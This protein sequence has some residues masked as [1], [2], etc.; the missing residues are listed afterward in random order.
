DHWNQGMV[1]TPTT[2][3]D[4]HH[5]RTAL[6]ALS[7]Q[8]DALRAR[9]THTPEGW[10]QHYL[11][12]GTSPDLHET[13]GDITDAAAALQSSFNLQHGPLWGAAL[14]QMHDGTQRLAIAAH[15]LIVDGVSWRILLE[16]LSR[17]YTQLSN[18]TPV[19]P[20][21]RATSVGRW[22]DLLA[23]SADLRAE[24]SYWSQVLDHPAA[25]LPLDR[26]GGVNTTATL[27]RVDTHIDPT[28]TRQILDEVPA[29]YPVTGDELMTA[30]LYLC[31]RDWSG[32]NGLAVELESH[33]RADLDD[34]ADLSRTVGWLTGL[35]PVH[36]APGADA[37]VDTVLRT[38]KETLR[39]VPNTGI[40]YGV[41]RYI[42]RVLPDTAPADVRF[43]YLGRAGAMF[44]PGGLFTPAPEAPGPAQAPGTPR[45][46]ALEINA[47]ATDQGLRIG[48]NFSSGQCDRTTIE[49][50]SAGFTDH[51]Q[52]LVAHCLAGDDTGFSP[53]DFP[54]MDFD[55]DDLDSLLESL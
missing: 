35:Y 28:L 49:T 30:A 15:H 17:I 32:A 1:L 54:D 42:H 50:L 55:Q 18:G 29:A 27:D 40:G 24:H 23:A 31:L 38:V 52:Q 2:P 14:C 8:H 53:S 45:D 37:S 43:N 39:A 12:P 6:A 3:L 41:L 16:D 46:I 22:A 48:W 10:Q 21:R 34:T 36:L 5:L 51:L 33:G 25:A 13:A 26:P 4:P 9:F 11:A 20:R 19:A 44:G 47:L 7:D